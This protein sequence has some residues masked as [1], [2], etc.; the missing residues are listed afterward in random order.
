M[1]RILLLITL[2]MST[3]LY[4]SADRY[5]DGKF[6]TNGA[7]LI[8]LP[9]TTLDM[10]GMTAISGSNTGDV[11][12]G[13]ANG[14]S[15]SGQAL[16]LQASDA[17]HNGALLATDFVIFSAKLTSALTNTHIFVG[18]GSGVATDVAV[19]GDATLSNTGAL[20][21]GAKKIQASKLDSGAALSGAVATADGSG[22][23]SY[24]APAS[25]APGLS[26]TDGSP[27]TVTAGGGVVFSGV[28]YDNFYFLTAASAITVSANPQIS[29]AT[30]VG[31]KL[32]I[33][34]KSASNTITLSD[35]TGLSLNG[36]FVGGLNSVLNVFWNGSLW[37]E[38]SR[39]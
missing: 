14:L 27:T 31:Q 10:S 36:P 22:G 25:V 34:T 30:N 2:M 18:N 26:G 13:T 8:T 15:L 6:I 39:R 21:I 37:V 29:A 4:A 19:S 11:T 17:T 24:S 1:K 20:T 16:S 33:T 7:A 35:G 32:T 3:V 9:T 23:V 12:I 5:L 28:A 38:K